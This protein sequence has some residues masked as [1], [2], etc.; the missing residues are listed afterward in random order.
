MSRFKL[1]KGLKIGSLAAEHDSF[2][3]EA[4]VDV[5]Y[6]SK[7]RDCQDHAFLVLGRAGSGKTALI[8]RIEENSEANV[9]RIDPD[10]LSMQYLQNSALREIARWGVN[11]EI[12]YKY[13][14]RHVCILALA[15]ARYEDPSTVP[16]NLGTFAIIKG[17]LFNENSG[18]QEAKAKATSYIN[19][20]AN[21][22]WIST[23]SHIKKITSELESQ[24]KNDREL[25]AHLGSTT[26]GVNGKL[27]GS[28]QQR[29]FEKMEEEHR[30]RAQEIVSRFQIAD[31]NEVV[32]LISRES[33]KD[34]QNPYY[35]V[36]DDLD[37]NWMPNES[38]YLELIKSLLLVVRELNRRLNNAKIIVA[39]RE[40]IYQRVYARPSKQQAQ[41]E[42]WADV[43]VR[44]KWSKADL[45]NL[46]DKRL[47]QAYRGEYTQDP[48][49]LA[50]L[51]PLKKR[52][53]DEDAV[54]YVLERTLMRPRD[55]I[56]FLNRAFE[57]S[58]SIS[59][60]TWTDLS[61]AEL[62]YS[63]SRLNAI[64]DE[65]INS[66]FGLPTTFPLIKRLGHRFSP[67]DISD[68]DLLEIFLA[69]DASTCAWLTSVMDKY[70]GGPTGF[71]E[72]KIDI[73]EAWFNVGL[74]GIR[75]N[76]THRT[77]LSL[78][79]AFS[80]SRD[81]GDSESYTTLKIVQSAL[82]ITSKGH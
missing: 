28:D 63:E 14:W 56:D 31:L 59:R 18:R 79:R 26:T 51:L 41:Q 27:T 34:G 16:S 54:S 55:L 13:L 57:E 78:D 73:L 21:T 58:D 36:I 29:T 25:G 44:V 22:F 4:F 35:L 39:L 75:D 12:F 72:A 48:P 2:L 19:Q 33:F 74:V 53:N 76:V 20:Y 11:L 68:D 61:N 43:Q 80:R 32:D 1:R 15:R 10:E 3:H 77:T 30:T 23:D 67:S 62:G 64:R 65:W 7:L 38:L 40:D 50:D 46:A 17:L 8:R 24:L 6:V 81:G 82:G 9:V 70:A 52:S 49:Q 66:Y 5:G 45:V 42:K 60:L 69:P 37:K 71:N 47:A